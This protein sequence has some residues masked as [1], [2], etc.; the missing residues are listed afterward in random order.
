MNELELKENTR[1]SF[2]CNSWISAGPF[3]SDY[4]HRVLQTQGDYRHRVEDA[5]ETQRTSFVI[6]F[7]SSFV[8]RD[9]FSL[10]LCP[11]SNANYINEGPRVKCK[12]WVKNVSKKVQASE[13]FLEIKGQNNHD[14]KGGPKFIKKTNNPEQNNNNH[15]SQ[16]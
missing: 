9:H 5:V 16:R 4:R 6:L 7:Y 13:R 2:D 1:V 8:Y 12:G 15:R 10:F 14:R 11:Q 3:E